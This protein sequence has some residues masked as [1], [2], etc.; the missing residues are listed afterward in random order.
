MTTFREWEQGDADAVVDILA[1]ADDT[2]V[3]SAEAWLHAMRAIPARG[4]E[5][6]L[7]A[8]EDGEVVGTGGG[9]LD[10]STSDAG[11]GWAYVAVAPGSRGGGIGAALYERAIAHLRG[12][13]ARRAR[14][15]LRAEHAGFATARGWR[16]LRV[17]PVVGVD[18][19]RVPEHPGVPGFR[20]VPLSSLENRL[21]DVYALDL[22]ASKDEPATVAHD[23]VSFEEWLGIQWRD[24]GYDHDGGTA[25]LEGERLVAFA[26]LRA[27]LAR[28]RGEN[29]FTA[30]HPD[31]RGRGLARLAKTRS[32]RWAAGHGVE[33]VATGNDETN[34]PMRAVNRRLGYEPVARRL[35]LGLEL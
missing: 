27:D 6:S 21:E 10:W 22:L 8:V 19:R 3:L 16:E 5:L 24:P 2:R 17:E 31:F 28:G 11:E 12:L 1:G 23:A 26:F 14:T 13:G 4:R 15:K 34:A 18:P 33:Q 20:A 35:E 7:V 30:T 9:G 32:L 29:G 25:V